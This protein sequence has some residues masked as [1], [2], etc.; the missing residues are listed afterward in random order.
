MVCKVFVMVGVN[1]WYL[2]D[3]LMVEVIVCV[4][5]DV[6][7]LLFNVVGVEGLDGFVYELWVV[8]QI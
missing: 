3:L 8:V 2:F 1:C 6:C 5:L 7:V 4:V